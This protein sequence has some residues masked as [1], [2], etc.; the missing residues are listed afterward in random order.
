M[1][2]SRSLG[3]RILDKSGRFCR[4][5]EEGLEGEERTTDISRL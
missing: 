3:D 4:T 2:A 1:V 5:R